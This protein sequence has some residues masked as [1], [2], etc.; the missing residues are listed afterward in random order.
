MILVLT[1]FDEGRSWKAVEIDP[2]TRRQTDVT[3]SYAV[4]EVVMQFGDEGPRVGVFFGRKM[5]DEERRAHEELTA[6]RVEEEPDGQP[7]V[8]C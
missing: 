5:T 3:D 2:D 1:L 6:G 8:R 4:R 7:T